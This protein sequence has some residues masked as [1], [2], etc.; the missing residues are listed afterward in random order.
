MPKGTEPTTTAST[1]VTTVAPTSEITETTEATSTAVETNTMATTVVAVPTETAPQTEAPKVENE[2]PQAQKPS[3]NTNENSTTTQKPAQ[4][5]DNDKPSEKPVEKPA[6]K[7]SQTI[8]DDSKLTHEQFCNSTNMNRVASAL[9]DRYV[10]KGMTY[11]STITTNNSGWMYAYQG[12]VDGQ[13]VRSYNEHLDRI[14]VGMDEQLEAF[15]DMYGAKYTDLSF[16]CYEEL[17]ADGEYDIY[18]CFK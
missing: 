13:A 2:K 10:A 5:T 11:D 16:N 17:Q 7:P 6:E 3:I 14:I 12:Q 8:T 15:M 1:V 4:D 9:I 18:F